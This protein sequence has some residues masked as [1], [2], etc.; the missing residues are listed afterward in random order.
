M[1]A[2]ESLNDSAL[3]ADA[4][5]AT[6]VVRWGPDDVDERA[7]ATIRLERVAGDLDDPEVHLR[8][9]IWLLVAAL[10]RLDAVAVHRQLRALDVLAAEL[11]SPRIR[12]YAASRRAMFAL[13]TGDVTHALELTAAARAAG[14]EA[15]EPDAYGVVHSLITEAARQR[16]DTDL[17]VAE[18]REFEA[19]GMREGI[20][21]GVAQAAVV[22]LA[23]GDPEHAL[24][25]V[26]QVADAGLAAVARD[27]DWLL[28]MT[29]LVEVASGAGRRELLDEAVELLSP[30]RGRVVINAGAVTFH[31]VVDDYI[32]HACAALGREAVADDWRR[33]ATH[34]YE[35]LGAT[36]W[37]LRLGA[38]RHHQNP[39]VHVALLH[40]TR[41]GGWLVGAAGSTG[42]MTDMKGL[43]YLHALLAQPRVDIS[44]LDLSDA[45]AGHPQ[46]RL[47][48]SDLGEVL[49]TEAL[50][51]YRR[52]L[53]EIDAELAE[54]DSWADLERSRAIQ[55]EREALL[56]EL[57]AGAGLHGRRRVAG[58]HAER[59]RVAVRKAIVAAIERIAQHDPELGRHLNDSVH[60]GSWCRYDPNPVHP[61][62]WRLEAP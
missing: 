52:R 51:D 35:R 57:R 44:A 13:V 62:T 54:A 36:W 3:L 7:T 11:Q 32:A 1:T 61:I 17:L 50:A 53:D 23:A 59:A 20:T 27:V 31:G 26:H 29:S 41:G 19:F 58:S 8:A 5:D 22:W 24:T 37:L 39:S 55:L 15:D 48:Q 16:N 10:E 49:D 46:Q 30:Y 34:A 43:H 56:S 38:E 9:R 18:A 6:L 14:D 33:D 25:L 42:F 2:A 28:T 4:L 45:V 40:S 21:S 47:V 12:F 60:T